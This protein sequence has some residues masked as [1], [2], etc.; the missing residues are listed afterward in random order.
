[1]SYPEP[2]HHV[3][4]PGFLSVLLAILLVLQPVIVAAEQPQLFDAHLHYDA[5]HF[6]PAEVIATLKAAGITRA[7]VTAQPTERALQ[8]HAA[9]PGIIV[10]LLG[11]YREPEDRESWTEDAT[12]PARVGQA[13]HDGVW[14]GIGELH[15]FA[16]QRHSPVF[17]RIAALAAQHGLPLLLHCDPAVIDTLYEHNPNVRVVWAHAGAYP[18]PALLRDYLGRYPDLYIDLSMRD[19]RIAPGG[20]L[21]PDWEA[22]FWEYPDRFLAGADTFS[23]ARWGSYG[24]VVARIRHW[25]GQL[26][27][28]VAA[29]IAYRNA[30]AVFALAR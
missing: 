21:D 19:E 2:G 7:A 10:P 11:V 30:A 4:S 9:A 12:L 24:A 8:L 6:T 23:V 3:S 26:P 5:G 29:G 14:R 17:L 28:D 16:P 15:L 18:Y 22:L 27:D 20:M 25:L 1:M 13:L